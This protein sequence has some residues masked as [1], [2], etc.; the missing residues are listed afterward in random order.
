MLHCFHYSDLVFTA[1]TVTT[2]LIKLGD[3]MEGKTAKKYE[4]HILAV[5]NKEGMYS[6][7]FWLSD[8]R[9]DDEMNGGSSTVDQ[10]LSV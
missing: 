6:P 2:S 1:K 9:M 3:G 4:Q 7:R 5:A 8:H 10:K